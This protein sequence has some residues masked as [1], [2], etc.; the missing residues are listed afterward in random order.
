M[1]HG[2]EMVLSPSEGVGGWKSAV[3]ILEVSLLGKRRVGREVEVDAVSGLK[4]FFPFLPKLPSFEKNREEDW[5]PLGEVG[6]RDTAEL[7]PF[8][9][10]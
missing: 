6:A 8:R 4:D 3:L 1:F 2:L 9:I 7:L 5:L 10:E